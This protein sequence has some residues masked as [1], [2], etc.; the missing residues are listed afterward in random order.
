MAVMR[1]SQGGSFRANPIGVEANAIFERPQKGD[2]DRALSTLMHES[3]HKLMEEQAR[4]VSE[5]AAR[6]A[7]QGNRV[8]VFIAD[9]ADKIHDATMK[10]AAQMLRDFV[11]R[12]GSDPK[13]ITGWARPHLENLNNSL[14]GVIRPNGFPADRQRIVAQYRAVFQQRVDGLLR[15]VEIGFV[16]GAGF[17]AGTKMAEEEWISAAQAIALVSRSMA[18]PIA[19][20]VI[21]RRAHEGLIK[22]RAARFVRDTKSSDEVEVP[23]EFWWA[24][25]HAALEQNWIAGDF[26]TWINQE[27]HLK[28]Y[29]VTFLRAQ[30]EKL[31]PSCLIP[32]FDGAILSPAWRDALWAKFYTA[33]PRRQRRSVEQYKIVKRA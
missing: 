22:A 16:R 12:I 21:C 10:E 31:A 5:A 3:R 7:L 32:C 20:Q 14:V 4:I 11:E 9:V 27:L 23:Q 18:R 33:A 30:I 17:S 13:L 25:G 19:A 29:G 24:E 8:I 2:I 26:E 1:S 6:G 15:D 28:A